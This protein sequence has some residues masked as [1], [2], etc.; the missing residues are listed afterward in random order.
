MG[1]PCLTGVEISEMPGA[2]AGSDS[3]VRVGDSLFVFRGGKLLGRLVVE[4]VS[5]DACVAKGYYK[6]VRDAV[7]KG[8]KVTF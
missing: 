7:R 3:G 1:T 5:E 8:D 6:S 4:K 2:D